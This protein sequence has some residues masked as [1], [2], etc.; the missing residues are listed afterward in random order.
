MGVL[1]ITSC[2]YD[3]QLLSVYF[4]LLG[5]ALNQEPEDQV[6]VQK[7]YLC[8]LKIRHGSLQHLGSTTEKKCLN[9]ILKLKVKIF[10]RN[11]KNKHVS[12]D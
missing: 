3:K 12:D 10:Y 4:E 8:S 9:F 2:K 11:L 7:I 1:E 6:C 5:I